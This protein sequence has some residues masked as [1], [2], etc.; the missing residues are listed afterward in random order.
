M[1]KII[2][3]FFIVLFSS[4]SLLAG[5]SCLDTGG[6][7]G[8]IKYDSG[9]LLFCDGTGADW[10]SMGKGVNNGSCAGTVAGTIRMT[11]IPFT[12]GE[13]EFCDGS[14]WYSTA[15]STGGACGSFGAIR[16]SGSEV[17]FCDGTNWITASN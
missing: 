2:F 1:M 13:I 16:L 3:L 6:Q 17:E 4:Q 10:R 8:Q 5:G 9:Q 15:V 11:G 12:G 7:T 14:D